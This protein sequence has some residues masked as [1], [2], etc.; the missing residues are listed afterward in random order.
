MYDE[1]ENSP[2]LV[3]KTISI[4]EDNGLH[5]NVTQDGNTIESFKPED[6]DRDGIVQYE[7]MFKDVIIF[8]RGLSY[9][10]VFICKRCNR[11]CYKKI[12]GREQ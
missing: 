1:N 2:T 3:T 9:G 8:F 5:L 12:H 6:I 10:S 4:C 7:E 11:R